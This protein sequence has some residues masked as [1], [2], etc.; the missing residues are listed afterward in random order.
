MSNSRIGSRQVRAVPTELRTKRE[1]GDNPI[2]E[3]YFAVFNSNYQISNDMSES[4]APG[5]F[6]R[7]LEE[8][9]IR[10]LVNHDTTLVLGRTKSETGWA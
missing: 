4:V 3:G 5:A 8:N 1:D 6:A 10:A 2:I 9:D 7:S